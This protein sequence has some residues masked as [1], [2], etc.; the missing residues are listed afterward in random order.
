[1]HSPFS[2]ARP[3]L[4][5]ANA[6]HFGD[7]DV[8]YRQTTRSGERD[9]ECLALGR[10][11]HPRHSRGPAFGC[12][13]RFSHWSDRWCE[14]LALERSIHPRRGRGPAFGCPAKSSHW[15]DFWSNP[16]Y[17]YVYAG[18]RDRSIQPLWHLSEGGG[19]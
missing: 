8:G 14:C 18:F 7:K 9:C 17:T 1:V 10:S 19:V 12:P 13:A 11:V 2:A 16:R 15:S 4:S 6:L 3:G 5:P